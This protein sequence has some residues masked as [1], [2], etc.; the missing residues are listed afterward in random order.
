MADSLAHRGPDGEGIFTDDSGSPSIGLASRR[1][2]I[3]DIPGG[4]QPM[5]A[6]DEAYT[7]VYNGELFNAEHVRRRLEASGHRFRSRCDTEVVLRGYAEWGQ[8]VVERLNGMWAFAVWDRARRALFLARDRLGVK[9]LVYASTANGLAFGSEIKALIAS[10]VVDRRVD[11]TALPF[12]LSQFAIP[13]PH[14]LIAGVRRLPAGH[15]LTVDR[16]GVKECQYWDCALA[17]EPDRG[18][19]AFRD[20]VRALLDDSVRRRLV[21]DVPLGVLLS[22]GVDS[23]L[24]STFA[25]RHVPGPLRTF[26]L[27]FGLPEADERPAARALAGALG[28]EHTE[29][30]IEPRRAARKLPDLLQAYDEPGQSL[31]Q[32]HFVCE[33]AA[34]DVTVALSGLGGDELFSAYPTHVVA[35]GLARL[36]R[37]PG[38]LRAPLLA[39][40][41]ALPNR[42]LKRVAQLASMEPDERAT[43]RLMHQTDASL[44]ASLLAPDVRDQLDLDAPARHLEH[45]YQRAA[46]SH[47][48]NRMLYVY[49]KTY[50][51]DELLRAS[52]AMSM[53]NSLE[54]RTPFLD[55]R[56]VER[57]M[58]IPAEHK[59]RGT[60]GKLLLR[61]VAK[62]VVPAPVQRKKRG[63]A[64]PAASWLR[65]E[66][67]EDVQ[68]LL[69]AES[70][71]RRGVFDPHAVDRLAKGC[72]AG[73]DGLVPPVMML[74]CYEE[75]ARRWLDGGQASR[76][77]TA[78]P[79]RVPAVGQAP[80]PE[81]SIIVVN[82]NTC[83]LLRGCLA[84]LEENLAGLDHE[85]IVVDNA[86]ADGSPDMVAADF[87]SVHLVRNTENVGFGR[88]NNQA[89]RL[90][91]GSWLLLL[92]SD[93]LLV[94]RSVA[95]LVR[96]IR[97]E[98]NVGVA[99]CRLVF[100]DGRQQHTVYR[101]PSLRL[102]L[103]EDL[104]LY[105]LLSKRRQ[106]ETLLT[107][108]WDYGEERD[109]DWVAGAFMLLPR[110]VFEATGGFDERLFMY[111]EDMEWC[112]RIRD[113]G[114]RIRYYPDATVKHFDHSS[115]E[116]R[117]GDE[118][119]ALC[120]RRQRDI[121]RERH[122]PLRATALM[123]LR[124]VGAGIRT[125]YY[126]V[127][128]LAGPRAKSYDDMRRYSSRSVRALLPLV[129]PRR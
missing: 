107:G 117:W 85:V 111:G 86:S 124:L 96:R 37:I 6:E 53:L 82:W 103:L 68:E 31:L 97:S 102:A 16:T 26:T 59:M 18:R 105:K 5:S 60:L 47:P 106:G 66:L 100:P 33:L 84:S 11:H 104:G 35:N 74:Y 108:Y 48:L 120:L 13:E 36:D 8:D 113:N 71:R 91:K 127:R 49:V 77:R 38:A 129:L 87:P 126:S 101:F 51:V 32:T 2:A 64:P 14:S 114:W 115:A 69:S 57:V 72:L 52:D 24:V 20:E 83:E 29:E 88:A 110:K 92:N 109:V 42:R 80:E 95:A 7:L 12:Y 10:G 3:I 15:T 62:Q 121:Y 27:G 17:E 81:L 58:R 43:R 50:L 93:T 30:Q 63:F 118:R 65:G 55:Y 45:H 39:L 40:A 25:A 28:A 123:T 79:V 1:L 70:V 94:D 75:W 34:R 67:R 98:Q 41:R 9:P 112:H 116:I 99:H 78:A 46:G 44:R 4:Q 73:D 21:S 89:M 122:G 23:N 22:G 119:I 61:D 56:L 54:L 19:Q 90:A 125:L 128:R 76:E